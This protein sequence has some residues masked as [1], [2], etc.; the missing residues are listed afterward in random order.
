[1]WL[2]FIPSGKNYG[3][4]RE[5]PKNTL[6]LILAEYDGNLIS[7]SKSITL[8][9]SVIPEDS[10]QRLCSKITQEGPYVLLEHFP[11]KWTLLFTDRYI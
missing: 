5:K 4:K 7:S 11:E 2:I 10:N 3:E 1:M 8:I 6:V 9:L